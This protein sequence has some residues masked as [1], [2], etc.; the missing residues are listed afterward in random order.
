MSFYVTSLVEGF[1]LIGEII[2]SPISLPLSYYA[3]YQSDLG[4][5]RKM[6]HAIE[7]GDIRSLAEEVHNFETGRASQIPE[8]NKSY[9]RYFKALTLYYGEKYQDAIEILY[10]TV[11][12]EKSTGFLSKKLYYS[13]LDNAFRNEY[14][15]VLGDCYS[16]AGLIDQAVICYSEA[17]QFF[18]K[19]KIKEPTQY[20]E[21]TLDIIKSFDKDQQDQ[22]Q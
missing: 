22:I 17:L 18:K 12:P 19:T 15:L 14:L 2:F 7:I 6:I 4:S 1:L 5:Y 11:Y 8:L 9:Y 20:L 21:H 16:R 10:P 13:W 3:P